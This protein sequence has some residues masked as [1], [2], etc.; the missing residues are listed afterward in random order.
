MVNAIYIGGMWHRIVKPSRQGWIITC[1]P[2]PIGEGKW[3]V[4]VLDEPLPSYAGPCQTCFPP[5]RPDIVPEDLG[6]LL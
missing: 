4:I 1:E 2:Y 5:S 3:R 6:G